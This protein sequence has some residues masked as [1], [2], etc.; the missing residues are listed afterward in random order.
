VTT[1]AG[2]YECGVCWHLYGPALGEADVDV[3]PGTPFE[4]DADDWRC[5]IRDAAQDDVP[6]YERR[7]RGMT[8]HAAASDETALAPTLH[9]VRSE[10]SVRLASLPVVSPAL[11]VQMTNVRRHGDWRFAVVV[12]PWF[13]N[14]IALPEEGAAL[15]ADGARTSI[16]P[17]AGLVDLVMASDERRFLRSGLGSGGSR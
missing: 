9:A 10:A 16:D 17:P 14:V 5:P 13:M 3:P 1:F 15:P 7:R 4:A 8:A 11:E 2:R 6:P 12:T